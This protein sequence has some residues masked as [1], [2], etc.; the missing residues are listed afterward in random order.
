MRAVAFLPMEDSMLR[1]RPAFA[2]VACALAL[3]GAPSTI[4]NDIGVSGATVDDWGD[5]VGD[6]PLAESFS[7]GGSAYNLTSVTVMLANND[8]ELARV[9]ASVRTHRRSSGRRAAARSIK[10]A[11]RA[12]FTIPS[13]AGPCTSLSLWSDN[14]GPA[15]GTELAVSTTVVLDSALPSSSTPAQFT[16]LFTS[17]PLA[18]NTRYWIVASSPGGDSIAEWWGTDEPAGT[19]I[20]SEFNEFDG[21]V[22]ANDDPEGPFAFEI[23]VSGLVTPPA[24]LTPVPPSLTLVLTGLLCV[25]LYFTRRRFVHLS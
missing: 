14:G 4:S 7:T 11:P 23:L 21:G 20:L 12:L 3:N 6:A 13:C 24:P 19:D 15:P 5:V 1:V 2:L 25:G 8:N 22:T 17:F 10:A 18:A 9:V 16:F